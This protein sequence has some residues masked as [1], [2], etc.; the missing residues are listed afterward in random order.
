MS[1]GWTTVETS[2]RSFSEWR[3]RITQVLPNERAD[4]EG[5][6]IGDIVE[7]ING[8]NCTN[9]KMFSAKVRGA[10]DV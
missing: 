1:G 9:Y 4:Q 6:R 5:V 8:K 10:R 2:L 7:T 3:I